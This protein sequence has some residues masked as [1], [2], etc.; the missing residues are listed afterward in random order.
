MTHLALGVRRALFALL[1]VSSPLA[2]RLDAQE[3]KLNA[4]LPANADVVRFSISADGDHA[5]YVAS[6]GAFGTKNHLYSARLDARSTP[7]RL[8]GPLPNGGQVR[9][10][11]SSRERVVFAAPMVGVA[12]VQLSSVPIEGGTPIVLNPP[13]VTGGNVVTSKGSTA[14]LRS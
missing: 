6:E 3:R 9:F 13:L 8:N 10:E 11:L 5:L 12:G 14:F 2:A 7:V 1:A 4:P